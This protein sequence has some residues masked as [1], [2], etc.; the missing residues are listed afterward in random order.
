M[1]AWTYFLMLSVSAIWVAMLSAIAYL[2]V[3]VR[4]ETP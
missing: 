4:A 1:S 3:H 2:V